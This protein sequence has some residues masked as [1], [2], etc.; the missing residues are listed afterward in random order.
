MPCVMLERKHFKSIM[1]ISNVNIHYIR[2][3]ISKGLGDAIYYAKQHVAG[4]PFVV[5]LGDTI[6]HSKVPCTRQLMNFYRTWRSS[7]IGVEQVEREKVIHYGIIKGQQIDE[8]TSIVHDLI[9]KPDI[10]H[11]P[12]TL[13][14]G[15]RYILSADIF[16]YI[17]QTPPGKN[18]EIQLTDALRMM[19]QDQRMYAISLKAN[20][21]ISATVWTT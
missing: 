10:E 19:A 9:E 2:Q 17:E 7:V 12:S 4:E 21:T 1:E 20:A 6:I 16:D 8:R 5:L 11:A 15:G 3:K 18:G 13:A 14:V